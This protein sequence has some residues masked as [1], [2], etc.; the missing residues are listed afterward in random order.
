MRNVNGNSFPDVRRFL[1][2][3]LLQVMCNKYYF[4]TEL[5][6]LTV[7]CPARQPGLDIV[8]LCAAVATELSRA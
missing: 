3:L 1:A 6:R 8:K 7:S 4:R 2:M 5:Q